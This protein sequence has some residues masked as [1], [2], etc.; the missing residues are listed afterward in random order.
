MKFFRKTCVCTKIELLKW[1]K[2][3]K[4]DSILKH[5][6]NKTHLHKQWHNFGSYYTTVAEISKNIPTSWGS[7]MYSSFFEYLNRLTYSHKSQI[8]FYLRGLF[9]YS[10]YYFIILSI[11][12]YLKPPNTNIVLL[13]WYLLTAYG[14][15]KCNTIIMT[16]SQW[17]DCLCKVIRAYFKSSFTEIYLFKVKNGSTR[18]RCEMCSML[19]EE[20]PDRRHE[21]CSDIFKCQLWTYFTFFKVSLSLTL[22]KIMF[23]GFIV[24]TLLID[25]ILMR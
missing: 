14:D 25:F 1:L 5:W 10:F 12:V 19:T 11:N 3:D 24:Q 13:I 20:T 16:C 18:K 6:S 4:L 23:T 17:H 2:Q 8:T 7:I 22:N 21:R 15:A 9:Y